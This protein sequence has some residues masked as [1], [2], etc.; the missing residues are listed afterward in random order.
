MKFKSPS[1][2]PMHVALISGHSIVIEPEGTEVPAIFQK[3]AIAR[4]AMPV[5][6]EEAAPLEGQ[7][8]DRA[9]VIKD[10][11]NQMLDS[12]DEESFTND[13]KPDLR[14]LRGIVGFTVSREEADKLF[15]EVTANKG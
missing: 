2:E 5:G 7:K 14:K 13:G 8:F 1:E 10:A 6:I 12:A 4:G 15:A 11:I 3:E 9:Q